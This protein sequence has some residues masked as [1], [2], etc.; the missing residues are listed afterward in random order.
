MSVLSEIKQLLPLESFIY[1]A[2]QA[3]LPYGEKSEAELH[4]FTGRIIAFLKQK[5][6]KLIVSA[7]NTATVYVLSHMRKIANVPVVGTVPVIKPLAD[8]S[9]TKHIA[10]LV[11]PA[12]AKSKYLT[13]LIAKYAQGTHVEILPGEGLVELIEAGKLHREETKEKLR[14]VLNKLRY[15]KIDAI[16]LGSTHYAFLRPLVKEIMGEGVTV[17]DSGAAIA[18]RVQEVLLGEHL[19]DTGKSVDY[20]YTSKNP[21]EF[22]KVAGELVGFKKMHVEK[23]DL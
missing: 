22:Q 4:D 2:D 9:K 6:V 5:Q 7:C 16:G 21:I 18:R 8:M 1:V 19:L 23:V 20:Y 10:V 13:D 12:T 14:Q 11:T 17:L 15:D 3:N